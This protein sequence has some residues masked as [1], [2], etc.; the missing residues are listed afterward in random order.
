MGAVVI[1]VDN[2]APKELQLYGQWTTSS[3][4]FAPLNNVGA[5]LILPLLFNATEV[6]LPHDQ[7][8]TL[9]HSH[10]SIAEFFARNLFLAAVRDAPI[11]FSDTPVNSV[12]TQYVEE[13]R[14][15][16]FYILKAAFG[17]SVFQNRSAGDVLNFV[18]LN[19]YLPILNFDDPLLRGGAEALRKS[20]NKETRN[21]LSPLKAQLMEARNVTLAR[22]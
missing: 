7:I 6:R 22:N 13:F 5:K 3:L 15:G 8:Y 12:S 17:E 16:Y 4:R 11:A 18:L 1:E 9:G 2:D 10:R 14:R 19:A 20:V 21:D